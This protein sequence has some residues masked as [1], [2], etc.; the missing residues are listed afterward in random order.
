[1]DLTVEVVKNILACIL[2]QFEPN[3]KY[4]ETKI[5]FRGAL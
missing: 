4:K 3:A 2:S 5:D 1:M